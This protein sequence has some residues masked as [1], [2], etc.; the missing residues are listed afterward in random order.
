[1]IGTMLGMM[2]MT[3]AISIP[4]VY[5]GTK[6]FNINRHLAAVAGFA[7]H[8][9]RHLSGLPDRFCRRIIHFTGALDSRIA[10]IGMVAR[11]EQ[12]CYP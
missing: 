10:S 11:I 4:L 7:Q 6:F 2:L 12:S 8:G 1:M 9:L 5:K 3:A